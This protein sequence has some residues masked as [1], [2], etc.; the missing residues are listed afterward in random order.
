M[1]L[2]DII[3]SKD[4]LEEFKADCRKNA[5]CTTL[6]YFGIDLVMDNEGNINCLE[7]NGQYS[8]TN[9]FIEAYGNDFVRENV[10]KY[11]TSFGLP[12]TIYTHF[13]NH[14]DDDWVQEQLGAQIKDIKKVRLECSKKAMGSL[15][16]SDKEYDRRRESLKGKD[17]DEFVARFREIW[18]ET[19]NTM[20]WED[21]KPKNVY[22]EACNFEGIIWNN[23]N[24]DC[25][26]DDDRFL[27]VNPRLVERL[28]DYKYAPYFLMYEGM[29]PCYYFNKFNVDEFTKD[30]FLSRILKET[31][32]P[33][34]VFKPDVGR[35][36]NGVVI[37]DKKKFVTS[38]GRLQ[39]N[40]EKMIEEPENHFD[41]PEIIKNINRL[42]TE[43]G[44]VMQPFIESKPFYN[45][46]TGK[47]HRGAIRHVVA[48]HSRNGTIDINHIGAYARLASEPADNST[49]NSCVANLSKGAYAVPVSSK[50]F[51][52]LEK[53]VNYYFKK[54]YQRALR[55]G[56]K[57]HRDP[58]NGGVFIHNYMF[59]DQFDRAF[60]EPWRWR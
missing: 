24:D 53:W 12:L 42:K 39:K 17:L 35:C 47:H 13:S 34:V 54:F 21:Y 16:M 8:G 43:N 38:S 52:R 45:P 3:V 58:I 36:G 19:T 37:L 9:G 56:K 7:I 2:G 50:D 55:M 48:V 11:F 6:G 33:K 59:L 14:D 23:T 29:P 49:T 44:V 40:L 10:I 27:V 30:G 31:K 25:V 26:F 41:D 15:E 4:Y 51:R 57:G 18:Y 20:P 32:S 1:A 28:I 22:G 5:H 46:K 60:N